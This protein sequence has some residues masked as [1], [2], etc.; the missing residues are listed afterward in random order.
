MGPSFTHLRG[1]AHRIAASLAWALTCVGATGA[2]AAEVAAEHL[3]CEIRYAS[4]SW[5]LDAAPTAQPLLAKLHRVGERFAFRAIVRAMPGDGGRIAHVTTQVFDLEADQEPIVQ[6]FRR[7]P[8][9]P[10]GGQVPALTGWQHVYSAVLGRELVHGCAVRQ[11]APAGAVDVAV[12]QP[13]PSSR[14][15]P[16]LWRPEAVVPEGAAA[17]VV[18]AEPLVRLAFVGDVMLADGPGR[19]IASG[20][21]P[22]AHVAER[23][24]QADVRI[25]NLECVIARGGQALDKPWTFRAHPRVLPVLQRHLD[26]VSVANNHVGDFGRE[27]FTE[28]LGHLDASGIPRVGGG[29]NLAEAHRPLI[30][31]KH[32]L[33]I[34][35]LAY[36]E[37]FPRSFEAGPDRPGSAWSD[38]EQVA[39][40]IRHARAEH[41]ADLVIPFMHWGSE[42][43][44]VSNARQRQLA[45]LMIDAGADAVVGAH[46]HVVQDAEVYR[47]KPIVY[48]L[49]NF[50]FDGFES[51][52]QR[53]GWMLFLAVDRSGVR[54]WHVE[55]V[56]ADVEGTP[57]PQ[58]APPASR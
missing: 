57:H 38:D 10:E 42:G 47:G 16:P 20:R 13:T 39:D 32:G 31:E 56:R 36:D 21:D 35:L 46:P 54:Q 55:P 28:M 45:R 27:A 52:E 44:P 50:V 7:S 26:A 9:W 53:T 4:E 22:F 43:E 33:R 30:I 6:Q 24:R 29:R 1:R 8:P 51:L 48:S 40:D 58:V 5:H 23:L 14:G 2:S 49:G 18:Q 11:G 34:A 41:R 37:F 19:V 15:L 12:P 17:T 25:G 3:H